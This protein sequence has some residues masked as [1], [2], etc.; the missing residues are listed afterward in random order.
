[1]PLLFTVAIAAFDVLQVPPLTPSPRVVVVPW[2]NVV[3]PLI[4]PADGPEIMVT[5]IVAMAVPQPL[6]TL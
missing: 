2:H 6:V 5:A 4:V 3:V 1:M